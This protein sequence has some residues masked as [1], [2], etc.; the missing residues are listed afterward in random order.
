MRYLFSTSTNGPRQKTQ[1]IVKQAFKKA[2]IEV[3]LKSVI[4]SVFFSSDVANPDTFPHFYADLQMYTTGPV[5]PDPQ[6]WMLLFTSAEIAQ[7]ENKWQGRNVLRWRNTE[8]DRLFQQASAET[9][10]V[11][12]AA[13]IIQMN[14]IVIADVAVIPV[15]ERPAV[16]AVVKGLQCELSAFD[17]YI[18]D[19]ANFYMQA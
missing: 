9:D 3:E 1:Q 4:S 8:F 10:P 2:G 11:K 17:S 12:R 14:D 13:L 18:W 7:K 15:V 6:V 5:L 16:A 19:I